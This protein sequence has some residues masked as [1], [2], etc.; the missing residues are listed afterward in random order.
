MTFDATERSTQGAS[1]VELYKFTGTFETYRYTSAA[2]DKVNSDGTYT[3]LSIRRKAV[4]SG[5]HE[6]TDISMDVELPVSTPIVADYAFSQSPPKLLLQL[7]RAHPA[8]LDDTLL[9]WQ[10]EVKGWNVRDRVASL[11]VPSVLSEALSARVPPVNF[12]GP[13]NHILGDARCGVDMTSG[14]NSASRTVSSVSGRTVVLS[15]SAF[16]ADECKGGEMIAG[17]ERR[18]IM[19]N[20]GATFVVSSPF[21]DLEVGD[22]VTVRR[23]CDHAFNGHCINRFNNAASFGG[24]PLVPDK[25]PFGGRL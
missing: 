9:M 21:A 22:S 13:C 8:D 23:G 10:G 14:A 18:M 19:S 2:T 24:F 3:A 12:Q 7:Y 25:N 17:N 1:P 16:S 15:S 20:S 5:T 6:D 11:R 4:K